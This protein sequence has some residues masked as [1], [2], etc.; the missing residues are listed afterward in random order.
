MEALEN[1]LRQDSKKIQSNTSLFQ[2]RLNE[3]MHQGIVHVESVDR[4]TVEMTLKDY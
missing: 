1:T 3:S 4:H 2:S